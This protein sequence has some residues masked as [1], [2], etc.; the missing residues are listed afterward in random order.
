MI[1]EYSRIYTPSPKIRKTYSCDLGTW[2]RKSHAKRNEYIVAN[3]YHLGGITTVV[4][5]DKLPGE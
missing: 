4:Y 3:K 2:Y 1:T 5:R